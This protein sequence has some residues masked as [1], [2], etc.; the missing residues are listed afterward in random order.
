MNRYGRNGDR[1]NYSDSLLARVTGRKQGRFFFK[2]R[3]QKERKNE[4]S[5][6]KF[7]EV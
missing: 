6:L 4:I 1:L 2:K 3:D 5:K 7:F